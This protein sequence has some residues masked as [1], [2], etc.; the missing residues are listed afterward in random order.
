M[1]NRNKE[2]REAFIVAFA[3][4]LRK[5]DVSQAEIARGCS[6]DA[7]AI[8]RWFSTTRKRIIVPSNASIEQM[9]QALEKVLAKRAKSR[10]VAL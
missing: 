1:Q 2:E 5:L 8:S 10:A 9:E 6:W 3:A 7:S 4:K